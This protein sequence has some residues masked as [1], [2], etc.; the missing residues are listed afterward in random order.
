MSVLATPLKFPAKRRA[1]AALAAV[2]ALGAWALLSP[3]SGSASR[4]LVHAHIAVDGTT[5]V[6]G[7]DGGASLATP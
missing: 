5:K 4:P 7:F 1:L 6:T 3:T 2:A